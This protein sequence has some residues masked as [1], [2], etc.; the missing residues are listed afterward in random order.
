MGC[1]FEQP[2]LCHL[3]IRGALQQFLLQSTGPRIRSSV[4]LF[5]NSIF[6]K[7]W[8]VDDRVLNANILR[9]PS[10]QRVLSKWEILWSDSVPTALSLCVPAEPWV[11]MLYDLYHGLTNESAFVFL[12]R[13]CL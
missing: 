13:W 11:G 10:K 3:L 8:Q 5:G 9:L 1:T 2:N 7:R 6:L 4:L 12:L